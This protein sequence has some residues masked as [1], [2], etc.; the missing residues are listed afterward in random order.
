MNILQIFNRYL[1]LGGE[2]GSV[3]RIANAI[4]SKADLQ[5]FYGSTAKELAHPL[6][7]FRMP[8][9]LQKNRSVL[10]K[11]AKLQ[12]REQFDFWQ[13]HN[14]FPAISVA[15]YELAAEL[16]VPVVQ[17]LHNYRLSCVDA[18]FFREGKVCR[19]CSSGNL[20][21]G[22]KYGCWRGSR[23]ASLSMAAAIRRVWKSGSVDSIKGFIAISE[24]QKR[25]HVAMGIPAEKIE[26]VHHSLTAGDPPSSMPSGTGDIFF[27]GRAT[28]EKGIELLLRSWGK[29]DSRGR[30]LR[31]T[32]DGPELAKMCGLANQLDL[33]NV[34]FEGFVPPEKQ[35]EIWRESAILVAPS[36]WLEPF[37]MVVLEA[38]R[39]GR[40]VLAT[41]HGSFPELITH[42]KDGWLAEPDPE[43]FAAT[44]QTAIDCGEEVRELGANGRFKLVERFNH[45]VWLKRIWEVYE[46]FGCAR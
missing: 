9:L 5:T 8:F 29:V 16:G 25:E 10:K 6:G 24:S 17:Y 18:T 33:N 19:E 20:I 38:W 27:L 1:E 26:V 31:I 32:G 21:P 15:V 40:P 2:E 11:I 30:R 45:E 12:E 3:D 37:G 7:R 4:R 28:E 23:V 35:A 41:N 36:V 34:V 22:V 39:Q 14:V 44:L 46:K 43:S 13:I 42:G